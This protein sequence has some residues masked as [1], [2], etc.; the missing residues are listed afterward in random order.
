MHRPEASLATARIVT[1]VETTTKNEDIIDRIGRPETTGQLKD[2]LVVALI[3]VGLS[4][5][6]VVPFF[7]MGR[8]EDGASAAGLRMPTTHDMFLH[9]DQMRSFDEGL[10]SG[11]AYPR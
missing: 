4:A 6:A 5:I 10:R 3:C 11:E 2:R 7:F 9:Y 8:A 1:I